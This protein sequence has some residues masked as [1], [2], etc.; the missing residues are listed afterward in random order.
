MKGVYTVKQV[1]EYVKNMFEQDFMLKRIGIKGEV[2]NCTY[3]TSGHIYF[4]LKDES[5]TISCVMFAGSRS[6]LSFRM[7]EGDQVVLL[8]SVSVYPR[9]GRYQVYAKEIIKEGA[10]ELHEKFEAL[11]N[12]LQEMGMFAPEYKQEIPKYVKTI[13]VVTAP[14]GAAVQDIIQV[15][16]R[17]NPFIQIILYPALV[18]GEGAA[19]SVANGIRVLDGVVKPDLIIVGRGGGSMEDLWAF[20]EKEVAEAIF[21]CTTPIISA[22][23]H[24]TDTTI[25]DFVSDMRAPTPSAAAELATFEYVQFKATMDDYRYKLEKAMYRN[26]EKTRM[27]LDQMSRSLGYLHPSNKLR[28]QQHRMVELEN[29]LQAAMTRKIEIN[30]NNLAIAVTKLEGLSPLEKLK[31]GYSYV[32]DDKGNN[33]SN[34]VDVTIGQNLSIAVK[35]GYIDANVISVRKENHNGE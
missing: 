35:D 24:E 23:G 9:D 6:G 16:R 12:E 2:S 4:S 33:I 31:Q 25:A 22:V 15:V 34:T 1:N 19:A 21:H 5:G 27:Q 29:R 28:E 13:G 26:V 20:N 3:H 18:Q 14:T 7:Q 32:A 10:G 30:K 8:G 17:R 11:K